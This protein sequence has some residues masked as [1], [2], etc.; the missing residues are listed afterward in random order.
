MGAFGNKVR[1]WAVLILGLAN[2]IASVFDERL[3]QINEHA[4]P[5]AG[6]VLLIWYIFLALRNRKDAKTP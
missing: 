3:P 5:E 4:S 2:L 6:L 1:E